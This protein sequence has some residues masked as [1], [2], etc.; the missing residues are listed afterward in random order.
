MYFGEPG[1]QI[2]KVRETPIKFM[3]QEYKIF[4][5]PYDL[6][7]HSDREIFVAQALWDITQLNTEEFDSLMHQDSK[8][9]LKIEYM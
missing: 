1:K 7:P 8:D 4:K 3:P 9:F 6:L 5:K 2:R